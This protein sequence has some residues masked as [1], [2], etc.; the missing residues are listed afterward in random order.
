MSFGSGVIFQ[1]KRA[2]LVSDN[3]GSIDP[4]ALQFLGLIFASL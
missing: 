3:N 1:R 4:S 2:L